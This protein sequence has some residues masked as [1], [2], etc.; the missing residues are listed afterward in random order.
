M[1]ERIERGCFITFEGGEGV[2]KTSQIGHLC[3]HLQSRG[4]EVVRTREPGGTPA[5]EEIR[6]LLV[7]GRIDRWQPMTEAL[8]NYAARAEH[9]AHVI[10]PALSRGLWVVSDR[11]S[12][13]TMAYQGF[14]QGVGADRIESLHETVLGDFAPDLTLVMNLPVDKSLARAIKRNEGTEDRYER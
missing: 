9:V 13:S 2:G 5:G 14:C 7:S 11:F 6:A 4:I 12:D 8:L 3:A 1:T 10:E